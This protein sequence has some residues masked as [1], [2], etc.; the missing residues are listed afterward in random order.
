MDR[1]IV[2]KDIFWRK[3]MTVSDL[4]VEIKQTLPLVG[5]LINGMYVSK[6]NFDKVKIPDGAVIEFIPWKEG[7]TVRELLAY[8]KEGEFICA[9]VIDGLLV[10]EVYFDETLINKDMGVEFITFVGG[11]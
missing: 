11:G 1:I 10:P 9:A 2:G 5:I 3:G 4:L 7:M 6:Q 8:H